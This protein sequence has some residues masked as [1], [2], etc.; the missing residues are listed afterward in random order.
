M[1]SQA[2]DG[3]YQVDKVYFEVQIVAEAQYQKWG[4]SWF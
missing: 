1:V 3:K 4:F 2:W